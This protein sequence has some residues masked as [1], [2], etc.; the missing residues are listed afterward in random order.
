M[1]DKQPVKKE[2]YIFGLDIG[3]SKV[4]LFVGISGGDSVRVVECGDFPLANA[5][6]F[7]SV[8]ERLK[9]ASQESTSFHITI[10][11]SLHF[12]ETKSVK[13]IWKT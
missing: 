1:D 11:V 12:P 2:D 9:R 3:A 10:K 7:D 13:K 5:D 6:E 8:V 4:N